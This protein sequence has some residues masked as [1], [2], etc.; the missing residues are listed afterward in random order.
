MMQELPGFSRGPARQSQSRAAVETAEE[1]QERLNRL[2]PAP[3][4]PA[5]VQPQSFRIAGDA[6]VE[7]SVAADSWHG[8]GQEQS[9]SLQSS[10]QAKSPGNETQQ[11]TLAAALQ[12][13]FQQHGAALPVGLKKAVEEAAAK[14]SKDV[15]EQLKL[16]GMELNR[17]TRR[18]QHLAACQQ[19]T[20]AAWEVY[21][22]KMNAELQKSKE[23]K[24]TKLAQWQEEMARLKLQEAAL[25][26]EVQRMTAV[27]TEPVVQV[28]LVSEEEEP[29]LSQDTVAYQDEAAQGQE[30][31]DFTMQ[32]SLKR[33]FQQALTKDAEQEATEGLAFH[34]ASPQVEQQPRTELQSQ[35]QELLR[36]QQQV[37]GQ[38]SRTTSYSPLRSKSESAR[39]RTSGAMTPFHRSER[40]KEE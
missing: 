19:Q 28:D 14:P 17:V 20:E 33:S 16:K 18:Q 11:E 32:E 34:A 30:A 15:G 37:L 3:P 40:Q 10:F 12:S 29:A 22:E 13:L 24:N 26:E 9:S 27:K 23:A 5:H 21:I 7:G 2:P 39:R 31:M 36:N 35:Q 8:D 38:A 6:S 1:K 25:K 4:P